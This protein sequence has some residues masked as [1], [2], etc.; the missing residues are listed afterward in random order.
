MRYRYLDIQVPSR[1]LPI[2]RQAENPAQ[3]IAQMCLEEPPDPP[4]AMVCSAVH[5][6][7]SRAGDM[8]DGGIGEFEP[9]RADGGV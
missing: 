8:V 2:G 4:V 7:P 9:S 3:R 6:L 5:P 1:Y